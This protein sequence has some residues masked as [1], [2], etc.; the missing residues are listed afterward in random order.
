MQYK[1]QFTVLRL[2]DHGVGPRRYIPK[3]PQLRIYANIA[4]ITL[5]YT[6]IPANRH[7]TYPAINPANADLSGKVVLITG[8]SRGIGKA[9]AL[10]I[11][12][13]GAHGLVLLARSPLASLAKACLSARRLTRPLQVLALQVDIIDNVQVEAAAKKTE[14]TFGRLDVV[15]NNAGYLDTVKPFAES[16]SD[17]WWNVWNVN[18][19]GIYHVTRAFLPLVIKCGGDKTII[20][21][22]SSLAFEP[23]AGFSSYSVRSISYILY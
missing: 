5:E 13:S 6:F 16:D 4:V 12:Q 7:D 20:S 9:L 14:E 15:I 22:S 23:V 21:L 19:R 17:E 11:A 10:S 2:I 18:V 1:P 3:S 8:A